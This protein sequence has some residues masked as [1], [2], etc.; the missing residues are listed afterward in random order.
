M[1]GYDYHDGTRATGETRNFKAGQMIGAVLE[2]AQRKGTPVMIQIM[3]DGSLSANS[4]V[5]TSAAGRNKLGWQG[6]NST[7]AATLFLVYSPNGRPQLRNGAAGQQIGYFSGR[8][9]GGDELQP[10]GQ[11]RQPDPRARHPQLHGAH[12]HGR[13]VHE[14]VPDAGTGRRCDLGRHDGVR[15][16]SCEPPAGGS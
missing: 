15:R 4:M 12:G 3:S 16:R 13:S 11:F 14:P 1:G 2:Y 9:L 8:R 6:D 10:R 5:D 7:V